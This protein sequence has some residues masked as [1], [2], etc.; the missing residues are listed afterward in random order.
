[1]IGAAEASALRT[2]SHHA[3]VGMFHYPGHSL[4]ADDLPPIHA[5]AAEGHLHWRWVWQPG[6][7]AHQRPFRFLTLLGRKKRIDPGRQT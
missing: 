1:M 2:E 6:S 5:V 7:I 4:F 3:A